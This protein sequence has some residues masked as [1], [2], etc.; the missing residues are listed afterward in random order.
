MLT[1]FFAKGEI[2]EDEL[3]TDKG[4]HIRNAEG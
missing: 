3:F 4:V 2:I 1:V